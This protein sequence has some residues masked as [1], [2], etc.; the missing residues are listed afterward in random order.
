MST[1][2]INSETCVA[3]TEA[4]INNNNARFIL[5]NQG[6]GGIISLEKASIFETCSSPAGRECIG[7][8]LTENDHNNARAILVDKDPQGIIPL[9]KDDDFLACF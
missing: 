2:S 7:S 9:G 3:T 6:P 5:T 4:A 1:T 8:A